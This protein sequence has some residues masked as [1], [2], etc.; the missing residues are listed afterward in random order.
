MMASNYGIRCPK[1]DYS[2]ANP[3]VCDS[4]GALISRI[5][6]RQLAEE[7]GPVF[8]DRYT[9]RRGGRWT[10]VALVATAIVAVIAFVAIRLRENRSSPGPT[11][12]GSIASVFSENFDQEV[13]QYTA[14]PVL[15]DFHATWCGPCKDLAPRLEQM[16]SDYTT[17]L[18]VVKVDIDH[19]PEIA[20]RFRVQG[21]PTL[22][23]VKNGKEVERTIGALPLP[24]LKSRFGPH[25]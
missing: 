4:C 7:A 1:C 17:K 3:D 12:T 2:S 13:T 18:K 8:M 19:D 24:Q 25:L 10:Q 14:T 15:V 22:V 20:E 16:A 21:V 5:K 6:A 11:E 23:L 9:G